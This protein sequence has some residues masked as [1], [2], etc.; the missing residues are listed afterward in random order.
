MNVKNTR[1]TKNKAYSANVDRSLA[2]VRRNYQTWVQLSKRYPE[3][4]RRLQPI[5]ESIAKPKI[6]AS[7]TVLAVVAIVS[8]NI[9]SIG[10]NTLAGNAAPT[11][12]QTISPGTSLATTIT[13]ASSG[14]V[15]CLNAGSYGSVTLGSATG[16]KSGEVTV[17]PAGSGVT[18]ELGIIL[19]NGV[20]NLT[21]D[22]LKFTGG[23]EI[24]GANT[25]NI[26]II[27]SN[28]DQSQLVMRTSSLVNANIS[29]D[30]NRFTN[31][32]KQTGGLEGRIHLPGSTGQSS[33]ITISN[34]YMGDGG[35]SDCIQDGSD[36]TQILNNECAHILP[37]PQP[38]PH[39]DGFQIYGAAIVKG[40]YIHDTPDGIVAFDGSGPA[41]IENN[42]ISN[43]NEGCNCV[44]I[45]LLFDKSS[46]IRHNTMPGGKMRIGY[47]VEY[48]STVNMQ[49]YDNIFNQFEV[50]DA[51]ATY[52]EH[53]N[54]VGPGGGGA[55]V[56]DINGLPS[57][58]G[59]SSPTTINGYALTSGSL[60]H[61]DASDNKDR[62][63]DV[64]QVGLAAGT[65]SPKTGDLNNDNAVN[66][67]DLSIL[68]TNYGKTQAQS[69]NAKTDLNT[70]GLVN[71][72][73]LS[74]I[75]SNY[76]K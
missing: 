51:G 60:G 61:N 72:F 50:A 32:T 18:A 38:G 34:N 52:S 29:I 47:K 65:S 3:S 12:T 49:I 71:I 1:V 46:I 58:V 13:N 54:L 28:F 59:G 55:G 5:A 8:I 15:I 6:W 73:D 10:G 64:S 37:A 66:V 48:P 26:K 62:G 31:F 35:Y 16:N 39:V 27:N 69:T 20:T 9:V 41:V 23:A 25:K 30:H 70:D 74:I 45:T 44:A 2:R 22:G 7:S 67:F 43:L 19:N 33:G 76:G 68:M 14:T 56:S 11:C 17:Q 75:L 4:H 36:G 24:L 21:F 42:I 53:H 63:A 57:F 40:N